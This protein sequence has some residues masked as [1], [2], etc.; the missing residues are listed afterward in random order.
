MLCFKSNNK[1]SHLTYG[2]T[3]YTVGSL[4]SYFALILNNYFK[5]QKDLEDTLVTAT[6]KGDPTKWP[7]RT[8]KEVKKSRNKQRRC[9]KRKVRQ[10][11]GKKAYSNVKIKNEN[12]HLEQG[13]FQDRF[14]IR[15]G[16]RQT[17]R[18]GKNLHKRSITSCGRC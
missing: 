4:K 18:K 2:Y 16:S 6:E 8:F 14:G 17:R 3:I 1:L 11:N 10:E 5:S 12:Y 15:M 7:F 13:D 9:R